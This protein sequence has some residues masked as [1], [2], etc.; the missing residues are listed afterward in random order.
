M[1]TSWAPV[2]SADATPACTTLPTACTARP[3]RSDPA[4]PGSGRA[5]SARLPAASVTASGLSAASAPADA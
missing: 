3:S 5:R 4:A 2:T 1:V